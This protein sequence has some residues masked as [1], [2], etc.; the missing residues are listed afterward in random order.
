MLHWFFSSISIPDRP[1]RSRIWLTTKESFCIYFIVF[2][3]D[4]HPRSTCTF[5]ALAYYQRKLLH[6]LHCFFHRFPSLID[7]YVPGSGLLPKKGLAYTSLFFSSI[8]I[9]DR[10]VRSGI[11]LTT[12]ERFEDIRGVINSEAVYRRTDN[13]MAKDNTVTKKKKN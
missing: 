12:K 4:F 5:R 8:S 1:V 9:P 2:F 11:W 3:I 6:I 10:P 13:T 7:L